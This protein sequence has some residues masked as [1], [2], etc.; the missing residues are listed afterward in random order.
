MGILKQLN[1]C[2]RESLLGILEDYRDLF[3]HVYR[4]AVEQGRMVAPLANRFSRSFG[5]QR[6]AADHLQIPNPSIL[7]YGRFYNDVSTQMLGARL[8]GINRQDIVY[9]GGLGDAL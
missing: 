8:G 5:E 7:G 4:F 3:V 1:P 9:Q 2:L 6:R